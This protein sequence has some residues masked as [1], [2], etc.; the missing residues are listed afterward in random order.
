MQ[1]A[2]LEQKDGP[3]KYT[4]KGVPL[5]RKQPAACTQQLAAR[6]RS[7]R[8]QPVLPLLQHLQHQ[9]SSMQV[10]KQGPEVLEG[11]KPHAWGN[12]SILGRG[13]S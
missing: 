4:Q 12:S 2:W 1:F 9:G 13:L 7:G 6:W 5:E 10:S 3:P 8:G 11:T